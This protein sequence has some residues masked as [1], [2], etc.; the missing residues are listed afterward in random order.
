MASV[1]CP[2]CGRANTEHDSIDEPSAAP[3]EG[4]LSLCWGCRSVAVYEINPLRLRFPTDAELREI[5]TSLNIARAL[6]A[7]NTRLGPT[8]AV[9][10]ARE[11]EQR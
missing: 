8:A 10:A 3:G 11:A 1:S 9:R 5:M 2:S 4:D 6:S 7:M